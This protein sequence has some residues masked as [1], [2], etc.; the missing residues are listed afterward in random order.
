[1][2]TRGRTGT[3]NTASVATGVGGPS[4]DDVRFR[5]QIEGQMQRLVQQLADLEEFKGDLETDEY[6]ETLQDTKE[7]LKEFKDALDKI[8][9]GDV[10]LL[11]T[12][13]RMKLA[14]QAAISDAF[15]TPEVLA[16]FT[17]KQPGQLRQRLLLLGGSGFVL[18]FFLFVP[19]TLLPDKDQALK[20][21]KMTP[22][23]YTEQR[24][25]VLNALQ[26]L[27]EDLSAAE[28]QFLEQ[29]MTKA[30]KDFEQASDE[31]HTGVLS[32][33]GQQIKNAQK[34]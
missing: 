18:S 19:L 1:M 15:K 2:A 12:L 20:L 33:A 29:H 27:G 16:M 7:Q 13:A 23:T 34:Q 21:R 11:S 9:E 30:M 28:S 6:E 31:V 26:K 22:E 8:T 4:R 25:E 17:Q 32:L 3:G 5:E 24:V 14:I 10:T